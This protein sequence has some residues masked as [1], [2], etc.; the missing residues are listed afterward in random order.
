MD[1]TQNDIMIVRLQSGELICVVSPYNMGEDSGAVL[2]T[3]GLLGQIVKRLS[4]YTGNVFEMMRIT[5][6]IYTARRIMRTT[7][8]EEDV[9]DA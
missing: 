7:W 3:T 6:P 4:D 8:S 1:K 5:M 9:P 2:T